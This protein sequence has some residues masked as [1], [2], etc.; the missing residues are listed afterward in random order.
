[1][2]TFRDYQ[3]K[4]QPLREGLSIRNKRDKILQEFSQGKVN[5][6]AATIKLL[7]LG[8]VKNEITNFLNSTTRKLREAEVK[9]DKEKSKGKDLYDYSEKEW[10]L[11][12]QKEKESIIKKHDDELLNQKE[13]K[14][15][16]NIR[17]AKQEEFKENTNR[18]KRFK[19][20]G[21]Y[22]KNYYESV[23]DI[24]EDFKKGWFGESEAF[25]IAEKFGWTEKL[26]SIFSQQELG[27]YGDD[28]YDEDDEDDDYDEDDEEF[29]DLDELDHNEAFKENKRAFIKR[30]RETKSKA[31]SAE[32]FVKKQIKNEEIGV[33]EAIRVL[34][35]NGW[36]RSM[37]RKQIMKWESEIAGS[38]KDY[39][40]KINTRKESDISNAVDQAIEHFGWDRIARPEIL[41]AVKADY[42]ENYDPAYPPSIS[43]VVEI[44]EASGLQ[45]EFG[46][47]KEDWVEDD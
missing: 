34:L 13:D 23:R 20:G 38:T 19:E 26:E 32:A 17:K 4:N 30:L 31:A 36:S 40:A 27:S 2:K 24:V 12:S 44:V 14:E 39:E 3:N 33:N 5:S 43:D 16:T 41:K 8:F 7:E 9:K 29:D 11:L 45:T 47:D 35:N 46:K 6:S 25:E 10:H 28:D 18:N 15:L 22:G 21:Y 37:A 42:S 1:M